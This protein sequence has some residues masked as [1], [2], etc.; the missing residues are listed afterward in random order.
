M[1]A[2]AAQRRVLDQLVAQLASQARAYP[3]RASNIELLPTP[4][5]F[6]DSVLV[7][8]WRDTRTIV[9][10]CVL[11]IRL[12]AC[13]LHLGISPS[14]QKAPSHLDP[15]PRHW[16]ARADAGSFRSWC[17]SASRPRSSPVDCRSMCSVRDC[18]NRARVFAHDSSSTICAVPVDD[19]HKRLRSIYCSR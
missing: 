4:E 9:L 2:L 16:I 8:G 10:V 19:A 3:V 12:S 7:C 14:C 6:Y 11:S 18:A 13:L 5:S 15:V 17:L 1:A